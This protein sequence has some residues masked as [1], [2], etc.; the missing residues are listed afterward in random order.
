MFDIFGEHHVALNWLESG[1]HLGMADSLM[2]HDPSAAA[3]TPFR[4]ISRRRLELV[5]MPS[6]S[7]RGPRPFASFN[8]CSPVGGT[9]AQQAEYTFIGTPSRLRQHGR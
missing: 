4:F 7:S 8:F 1:T 5:I 3:K 9:G 2:S 6:F